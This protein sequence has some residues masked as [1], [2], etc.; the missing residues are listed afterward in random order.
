VNRKTRLRYMGD[1]DLIRW[2]DRPDYRKANGGM[3]MCNTGSG[4][5]INCVFGGIGCDVD[6]AWIGRNREDRA[7]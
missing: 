3:G 1:P 6:H 5:R 4:K 7:A 2:D